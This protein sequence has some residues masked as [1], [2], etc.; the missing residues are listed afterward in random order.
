MLFFKSEKICGHI[1]SK[2]V[3]KLSH[4]LETGFLE[5][6]SLLIP[7]QSGFLGKSLFLVIWT[8]DELTG[9]LPVPQMDKTDFL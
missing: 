7:K 2:S 8:A 3:V 9:I 4:G 1:Y 5:K 6:I